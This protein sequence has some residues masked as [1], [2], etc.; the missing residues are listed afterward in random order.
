MADKRNDK[1]KLLL[2]RFQLQTPP[3][4]FTEEVMK[5]IEFIADDKVYADSR[6]VEL[7][8]KNVSAEPSAGFTFKVINKVAQQSQGSYPPII[9]KK[10]WIAIVVF[11]SLCLMVS[12]INEPAG[13]SPTD[14]YFSIPLADY[15]GNLTAKFIDQLF[16]LVVILCSVTLLL[17]L[18]HYF[19]RKL[20]RTP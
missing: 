8:Q 13:S 11:V 16:Y 2:R 4:G 19:R 15:L 17:T 20:R 6:L 9:S 18:D 1:L 7:L 10:V 12:V 3:D 14:G 5:E